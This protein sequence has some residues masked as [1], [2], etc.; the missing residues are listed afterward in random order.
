M[1]EILESF[2]YFL[3]LGIKPRNRMKMRKETLSLMMILGV[4]IYSTRSFMVI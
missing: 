3:R 2:I 4:K 1:E